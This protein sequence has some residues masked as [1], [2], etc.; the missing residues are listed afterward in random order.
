[1]RFLLGRSRGQRR[2]GHLQPAAEPCGPLAQQP[3]PGSGSQGHCQRQATAVSP[4]ASRSPCGDEGW[5]G[6]VPGFW[7][8]VILLSGRGGG[9]SGEL[10]DVVTSDHSTQEEH[11]APGPQRRRWPKLCRVHNGQVP[12]SA[13]P[14]LRQLCRSL[15]GIGCHLVSAGWLPGLC[16][17]GRGLV[18]EEKRKRRPGGALGMKDSRGGPGPGST[19][20][21]IPV[22]ADG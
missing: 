9:V 3:S 17:T 2:G 1:M 18:S 15:A 4:R 6:C 13:C 8:D 19:R 11:V 20:A 22:Q 14:V 21:F 5:E 12:D 16:G 7:R 10:C